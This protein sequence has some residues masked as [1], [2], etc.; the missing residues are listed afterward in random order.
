[1]ATPEATPD[2]VAAL[3]TQQIPPQGHDPVLI[4]TFGPDTD[5]R[6]LLRLPSGRIERV[7]SGDRLAGMQITAIAPGL[8]HAIRRGQSVTLTI[9]GE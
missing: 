9:P 3:A 2:N 6:A 5:A 7:A 1:M 4:G 8:L